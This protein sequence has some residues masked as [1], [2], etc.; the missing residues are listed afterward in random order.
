MLVAGAAPLPTSMSSEQQA[1]CLQMHNWMAVELARITFLTDSMG[2]RDN[3]HPF[4]TV[5]TH[6]Q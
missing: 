2:C 6:V 1:V 5:C 4:I 3:D